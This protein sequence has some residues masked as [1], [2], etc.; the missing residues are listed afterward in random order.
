MPGTVD[1][2]PSVPHVNGGTSGLRT[3][4]PTTAPAR[5]ERTQ[6][7]KLYDLFM[8]ALS[9]L[10]GRPAEEILQLAMD[11]VPRYG[12]C[13]PEGCYLNRNGRFQLEATPSP[14]TLG[15]R[16]PREMPGAVEQFGALAGEDGPV[17]F[18]EGGWGWA[19]GLRCAGGLLGYLV[20]SAPEP[21]PDDTRFLL[22]AL[23]QP[24]A[25]ALYNADFR[26]R[27]REYA[28]QLFQAV[29]EREAAN[30]RL[31]ALVT[32][33]ERQRVVHDVLGRVGAGDEGE[34]GIARA[35]HELTGLAVCIEDRFGNVLA[36]AGPGPAEPDGKPDPL[37]REQVLQDAMRALAPVRHQGRLIGL[38]RHHGEVL[39]SV[40][41]IDP[42]ASA[43][44]AEAFVLEYACTTLTLELAHR[45]DL[46]EVELRLSRWLVDDLLTG[47]DE[48]GAYA[49]ADAIG[50][51]LRGPHYVVVVQWD[52]TTA[53]DRFMNAVGRAAQGLGLRSLLARR[54][55]TAVLVVQG[56]PSDTGLYDAVTAE[57]GSTHGAVGIGSPCGTTSDIPHSFD[58]A[59]RALNV[60]RQSQPR[61]GTTT[62]QELGLY[63][64][65]AQ[66]SDSEDVDVFLREW[67][68]PLLDYDDEHGTDLVLSLTQYFDHGGNYDETA[69]ALAVH[70]STLRYRLRRIREVGGRRLD[71]VDSRFNLQVATRIWKVSGP[72]SR[73][74]Q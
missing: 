36:R 60:R 6:L 31:T 56:E 23:T 22:Y 57:L 3:P 53:D 19:A 34:A 67:L 66:G 14:E 72:S 42:A 54:S 69:R 50:H 59:V 12:D 4:A 16:V 43:G 63:R 17:S 1:G 45:R 20:V 21:P 62:Y 29:E 8:L 25:A 49:R 47:A 61:H 40:E 41:L 33:L 9:M 58:R 68:G 11:E 32:E 26:R 71:D 18:R 70:R 24:T 73:T 5:G 13:R 27:D 64:I 74:G 7:N 44:A 2:F 55:E 35:V 15:A 52:G 28:R 51:D 48:G 37:L 39:G 46:A 38:A 30:E 10:D 65:L